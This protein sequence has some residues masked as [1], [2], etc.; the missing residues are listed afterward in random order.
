MHKESFPAEALL[1]GTVQHLRSNGAQM[2][3]QEEECLLCEC[4]ERI[5]NRVT[6]P[7]KRSGSEPAFANIT[8]YNRRWL[9]CLESER[10]ASVHRRRCRRRRRGSSASSS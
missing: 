10:P 4:P 8:G 2:G 5:A 9:Q 6:L 3:E 7:L 1:A